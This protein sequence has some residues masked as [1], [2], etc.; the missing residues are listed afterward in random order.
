MWGSKSK[1]IN[2]LMYFPRNDALDVIHETLAFQRRRRSLLYQSWWVFLTSFL[3]SKRVLGWLLWQKLLLTFPTDAF[4][5]CL[6]EAGICSSEYHC[7]H[8]RCTCS[9]DRVGVGGVASCT[10]WCRL[11]SRTSR[12]LWIWEQLL[13]VLKKWVSKL[14]G[15]K[16]AVKVWMN[17]WPTG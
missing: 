13:L 11:M 14:P 6:L 7:N 12:L 10:A 15:A 2:I 5:F 4:D 1:C 9:C 3:E 17:N 8:T 16:Q